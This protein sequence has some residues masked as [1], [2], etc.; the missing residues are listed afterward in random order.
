[1]IQ[2]RSTASLLLILAACTPMD[3]AT[4]T[5]DGETAAEFE[6]GKADN[7][8]SPNGREYDVKGE[9]TIDLSQAED[10]SYSAAE[11]IATEAVNLVSAALNAEFQRVWPDARRTE[12]ERL[13]VMMRQAS[14]IQE[15]LSDNGDGTYTLSYSGEVGAPTDFLERYPFAGGSGSPYIDLSYQQ[16]G[17]TR[18]V[19]LDFTVSEATEDAYPKYLELFE[20]GLDIA[21]HVGGD[22]NTPRTDIDDARRYYNDLVAMGLRSPVSSFGQLGFDS[23]PFTGTFNNG[24]SRVPIRVTLFHREMLGTV[25]TEADVQPAI[26]AY[27]ESA[28]TA[29]VVIYAGHAGTN[30]SYSG[31]VFHY[32]PRVAIAGTDFRN[33]D[34]PSKYQIFFFNGCETYTGY[35]DQLY[36]NEAKTTENLDVI[37]TVN[38]AYLG[39]TTEAFVRSLIHQYNGSWYPLTWDGILS[40]V[41]AGR[42]R[43][44]A[45]T[46][47]GVHG[48][49][50]NP[51]LSPLADYNNVGQ[52]CTSD[53]NCV[54]N[55]NFC[56]QLRS[57]GNVCG[58]GC[59]SDS[60]CPDGST[61]R[62]IQFQ[63]LDNPRQCLPTSTSN[64]GAGGAGSG[65]TGASQPQTVSNPPPPPSNTQ[66]PPSTG[67]NT[68]SAGGSVSISPGFSPDPSRY[69]GT[70]GRGVYWPGGGGACRG[71]TGSSPDLTLDVT[72]T[73]QFMKLVARSQDD[74]SL[75]MELPGGSYVC[76][77]DAEGRNPILSGGWGPG[78]YRIWV[79]GTQ[80]G[81]SYVMG[82]GTSNSLRPSTL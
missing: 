16:N 6:N 75:I 20:D 81:S 40:R 13:V 38:F 12:E 4:S 10:S 9:I 27:R 42:G 41:E 59:T 32:E 8:R 60:A 76:S 7:Y 26:D 24:G 2:L 69:S 1:M 44:V 56:V 55:G 47:Y 36:L 70:S 61:C 39:T 31:V 5:G 15:S 52:S 23:G 72:S 33:L 58:A 11:T 78:T 3:M 14:S 67:G 45:T 19:R 37:T 25:T 79:G 50:D 73:I 53:R 28:R 48:I 18:N 62:A 82:F 74:I 71:N 77:D 63:P 80:Y 35:A 65:T 30:L 49:D 57:G 17:E 51:K 34:L 21:I 68:Q 66:P 64:P 29:D 43:S 22:H 46:I 54:G